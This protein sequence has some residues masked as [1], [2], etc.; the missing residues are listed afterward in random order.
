MGGNAKG[1]RRSV[2]VANLV[3]AGVA[4]IASQHGRPTGGTAN[5]IDEGKK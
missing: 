5:R 4:F 1:D 3:P 2:E